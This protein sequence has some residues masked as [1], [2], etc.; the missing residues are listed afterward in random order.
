MSKKMAWL[1]LFKIEWGKYV[2]LVVTIE[3]PNLKF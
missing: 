3:M 2:K 1:K